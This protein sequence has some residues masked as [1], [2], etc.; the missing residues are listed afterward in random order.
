MSV[1]TAMYFFFKHY[2]FTLHVSYLNIQALQLLMETIL[3]PILKH[4]VTV[5][6]KKGQ[7]F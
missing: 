3:E 4:K 5:T 6:N 2:N 7:S 1:L